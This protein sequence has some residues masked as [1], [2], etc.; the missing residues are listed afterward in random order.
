LTIALS[1]GTHGAPS[2]LTTSYHI[3]GEHMRHGVRL[4]RWR[5]DKQP[6]SCTM[7]GLGDLDASSRFKFWSAL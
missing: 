6:E 3:T 5:T 7:A 4:L 1:T 2:G